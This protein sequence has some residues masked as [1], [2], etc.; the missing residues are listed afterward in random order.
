MSYGHSVNLY[1]ITTTSNN[2]SSVALWPLEWHLA[3]LPNVTLLEEKIP[4]KSEE[5]IEEVRE[6]LIAPIINR[7]RKIYL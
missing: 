2:T 6:E 3:P 7:L 1:N 4:A 5:S